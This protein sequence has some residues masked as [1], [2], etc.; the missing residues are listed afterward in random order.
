MKKKVLLVGFEDMTEVTGAQFCK[1]PKDKFRDLSL[2]ERTELIERLVKEISCILV[3][4][5]DYALDIY[6][7]FL[8]QMAYNRSTP[9]LV[10]G[11]PTDQIFRNIGAVCFKTERDLRIHLYSLLKVK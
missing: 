10:L 7:M 1:Y 5:D 11:Q 4:L 8:F 6:D 2:H 9:V 3:N